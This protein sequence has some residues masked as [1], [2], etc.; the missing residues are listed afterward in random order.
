MFLH[1]NPKDIDHVTSRLWRSFLMKLNFKRIFRLSTLTEHAAISQIAPPN[2]RTTKPQ[3][4][5][6]SIKYLIGY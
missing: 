5:L 2:L 3:T 6:G 1:L 4:R